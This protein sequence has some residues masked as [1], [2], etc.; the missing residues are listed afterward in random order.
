MRPWFVPFAGATVLALALALPASA[1]IDWSGVNRALGRDG[2]EQPGGVHRYSFPRS[3]LKV[4]VDG[5]EV[6][7]GLAL[8][9]WLAFQPTRNN[10]AMVVGDLVLLQE[11][12]PAV[13][14]TLLERG[15]GVTAIH[16]HL[17]RAEP[18]PM[19][20][21]VEGN[22]DTLKLAAAL[23]EAL[24]LTKI[25]APTPP[26]AAADPGFDAQ[27]IAD[28]LGRKGQFEGGVYKYNIARAEPI[29]AGHT[30]QMLGAAH[31]TGIVLNFQS[32]GGG[33]VASTG[34]FVLAASEVGPAMKSLRDNNIEVTALHSHMLDEEPRLAF[35]HFWA[36]GAPE[37]VARGLRAA[38]D[39]VALQQAAAN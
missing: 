35:L 1:E 24:A 6:K 18:F 34:D 27:V 32:A 39:Q 25:P 21:H 30:D 17:L 33:R 5:I 2:A 12:V 22:G 28:A 14:K 23:Q 4:T 31:G 20:V 16:N 36:V 11:E 9:G 29:R 38:L 10:D 37:Q 26:A 7:P 13:T 3:D 15:I 8:G 19:C